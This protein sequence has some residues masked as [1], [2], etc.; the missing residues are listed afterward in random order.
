MTPAPPS[1]V[2]KVIPEITLIPVPSQP[3]GGV[4]TD[5]LETPRTN[6]GGWPV[7]SWYGLAYVVGEFRIED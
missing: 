2:R 7:F 5:Q 1:D 3:P 4:D 6:Y